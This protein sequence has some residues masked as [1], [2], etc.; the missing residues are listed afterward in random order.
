MANPLQPKCLKVLEEEFGAYA[1]NLTA[2]SK[3]GHMDIVCCIPHNGIGEF[4]GFEIK[5]KSD[6]PSEL[7]KDKINKCVK[8]GGRAYFI[9]SVD[10]LRKVIRERQ[11]PETFTFKPM[12][13]I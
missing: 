1:I 7:Q 12:V 3:S 4:W 6:V 5:W 9:R 13:T 8:A 2:A 11:A 10:Q